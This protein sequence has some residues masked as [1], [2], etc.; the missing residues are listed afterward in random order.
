MNYIFFAVIAAI[1]ISIA[2]ISNKYLME[3]GISSVK[4][5][6]WT[7]GVIYSICLILLITILLYYPISHITNNETNLKDMITLPNDRNII[8][9]TIIAGLASF[10]AIFFIF[11]SFKLSKNIGYTVAIISSTC[12]FTLLLSKYFFNTDINKYGLMGIMMVISGVYLISLTNN[13]NYEI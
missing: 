3:N 5:T 9:L 11:F 10:I 13:D 7:H 6:F 4:Y 1:C 12:I 8:L 2:D